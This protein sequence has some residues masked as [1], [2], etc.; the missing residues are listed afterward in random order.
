MC[1]RQAAHGS[2]A[3]EV[4]GDELNMSH[5]NGGETASKPRIERHDVPIDRLGRRL[6]W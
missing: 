3:S 6:C 5:K 1:E 2:L 4:D